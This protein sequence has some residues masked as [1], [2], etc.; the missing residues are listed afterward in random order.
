MITSDIMLPSYL[1]TS[2]GL[3]VFQIK[4]DSTFEMDYKMPI[5]SQDLIQVFSISTAALLHAN[6]CVYHCEDYKNV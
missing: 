5:D 6:H 3:T 2:H 4:D 1:P